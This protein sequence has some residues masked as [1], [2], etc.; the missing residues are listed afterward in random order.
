VSRLDWIDLRQPDKS[1]FLRAPLAKE[2]GGLARC[3]Q[4]IYPSGADPDYQALRQRVEAAVR[5]AWAAPRRDLE[6]LAS[7]PRVSAATQ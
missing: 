5:R 7:E 2:A 6:A 4:P 3:S 1:L